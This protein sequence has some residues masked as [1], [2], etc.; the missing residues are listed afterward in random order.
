MGMATTMVSKPAGTASSAVYGNLVTKSCHVV[1]LPIPGMRLYP[2]LPTRAFLNHVKYCDQSG[3][4]QPGAD[5]I[6]ASHDGQTFEATPTPRAAS[7]LTG[8]VILGVMYDATAAAGGSVP[9]VR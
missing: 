7:S 6:N 5:A 9:L 3:R 8:S 2:Q 4:T 1:V